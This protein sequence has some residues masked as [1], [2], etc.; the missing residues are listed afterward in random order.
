MKLHHNERRK[1]KQDINKKQHQQQQ[2]QKLIWLLG[3]KKVATEDRCN[4]NSI[5]NV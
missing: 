1:M 4:C 3:F 2:Q 5:Y